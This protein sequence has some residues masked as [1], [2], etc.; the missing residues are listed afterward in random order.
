MIAMD[1][2]REQFPVDDLLDCR[3]S[4]VE[5]TDLL[6]FFERETG[7][8]PSAGETHRQHEVLSKEAGRNLAEQLL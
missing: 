5:V 6:T 2:R 4:G 7:E 8:E 1:D 3:M